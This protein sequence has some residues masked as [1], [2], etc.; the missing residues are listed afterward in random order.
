MLT[1]PP[2]S[3]QGS[4]SNEVVQRTGDVTRDWGASSTVVQEERAGIEGFGRFLCSKVLG[5]GGATRYSS[6]VCGQSS[7]REKKTNV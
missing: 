2:R 5:S 7:A 1:S 6:S 3:E 4:S